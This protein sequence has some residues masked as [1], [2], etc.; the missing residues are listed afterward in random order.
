VTGEFSIQH[1]AFSIQQKREIRAQARANRLRQA[2]KDGLSRRICHALAA[3]PEYLRA[4]TVMFYV[5]LGSEVRTRPFLPT[6]WQDGKRVVV[7][8]CVGEQLGLFCLERLDE[9]APGALGILEPTAELRGL[10]DRQVDV[11]R[12][13][14]IVVPG[15]AFDRRGGRLG[16]GKGYYDRLLRQVRPDATL[17]ALAF[18]CQLFAEIP[19]LPHD[20]YMHKVISEQAVYEAVNRDA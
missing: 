6:A 11:S 3:L 8:Y 5:E 4:R 15:V 19:M 10:A 2:D 9:L 18:E 7:P 1:S 20:V 12:L 16:R 13:D 14:L 17:V